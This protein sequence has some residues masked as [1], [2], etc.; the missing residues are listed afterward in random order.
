MKE[1]SGWKYKPKWLNDSDSEIS[2]KMFN[3]ENNRISI[4]YGRNGSGKTTFAEAITSFKE[5]VEYDGLC[6][7]PF[8][9]NGNQISTLDKN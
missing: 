7:Y 9:K 8:D 6:C 3:G 4:I 5:D 1:V 2:W